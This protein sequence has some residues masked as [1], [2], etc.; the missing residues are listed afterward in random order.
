MSAITF[1]ET[2]LAPRA[3]GPYS[4]AA[5]YRNM[6][7][8]SG[9]IGLLPQGGALPEN[10]LDE[11]KNALYNLKSITEASGSRL[12]RIFKVT[13]FLTD[14]SLFDDMNGIYRRFFPDN[15]PAR[16]C[17]AVAE[18]P[19]GARIEISAQGFVREDM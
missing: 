8:V 7:F 15:Y 14:M 2:P 9:Q 1:V 17:V 13:V 11:A 10:F 4:Q 5:V 3:V 16:E 18:L 6:L 12:D 19:K